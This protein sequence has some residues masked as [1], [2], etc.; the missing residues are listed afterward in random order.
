LT[1]LFQ[2]NAVAP[3]V[4]PTVPILAPVPV[5]KPIAV[6]DIEARLAAIAPDAELHEPGKDLGKAPV[7]LPCVDV[8]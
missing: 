6:A 4:Q 5:I 1:Q 8:A 3:A 2:A 7:E